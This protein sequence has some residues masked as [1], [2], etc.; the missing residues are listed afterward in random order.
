MCYARGCICQNETHHRHLGPVPGSDTQVSR[1]YA[2]HGL[3]L[4]HTVLQPPKNEHIS[5][6]VIFH[7]LQRRKE[8]KQRYGIRCS[9]GRKA[10]LHRRKVCL[11]T[12]PP[13]RLQNFRKHR[14]DARLC[15]TRSTLSTTLF[16]LLPHIVLN[17]LAGFLVRR[18]LA[19]QDMT[20]LRRHAERESLG[21]TGNHLV[22]TNA[23]LPTCGELQ[24]RPP[25]RCGSL[26][27]RPG[28]PARHCLDS[29]PYDTSILLE[30][31]VARTFKVDRH[32]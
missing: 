3:A 28:G 30:A 2:P 6:L 10:A 16:A 5:P 11:C 12:E 7:H 1:R 27:K 15:V 13:Q 18:L 21:A 4:D 19:V 31:S 29:C 32:K 20:S 22:P 17:I 24:R 26:R 23:A 25:G 8:L 9:D 14:D